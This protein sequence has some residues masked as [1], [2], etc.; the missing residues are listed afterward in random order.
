MGNENKLLVK[1][2]QAPKKSVQN[3]MLPFHQI[4]KKKNLKFEILEQDEM[5]NI[6]YLSNWDLYELILFNCIQNGSKYSES[7]S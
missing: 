1:S 3:V 7:N 2:D 4:M 5:M 6:K